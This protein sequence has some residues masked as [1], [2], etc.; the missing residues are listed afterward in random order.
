MDFLFAKYTKINDNILNFAPIST[1]VLN[2]L[3]QL[4]K[5]KICCILV[6]LLWEVI[7]FDEFCRYQ[8]EK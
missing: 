2:V 3:G 4:H 1:A 8:G 5:L 6:L 7:I